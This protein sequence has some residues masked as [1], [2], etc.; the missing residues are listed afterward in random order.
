MLLPAVWLS[1]VGVTK[2]NQSVPLFYPVFQYYTTISY[3]LN[4]MSI[5]DRC[6][7]SSAVVTLI[8]Y[9]CDK[10]NQIFLQ[11]KKIQKLTDG[12]V[13]PTPGAWIGDHWACLW[14]AF[15]MALGVQPNLSLSNTIYM[16]SHHHGIGCHWSPT[17]WWCR[18]LQ[19]TRQHDV[20][21]MPAPS[22]YSLTAVWLWKNSVTECQREISQPFFMMKIMQV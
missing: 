8:K 12:L 20:F 4:I 17:L 15:D 13:T 5:F 16:D 11:N 19:R 18:M 2:P 7:H 22:L 1:R 9:G 21:P 3:P 14:T 10:K 6:H